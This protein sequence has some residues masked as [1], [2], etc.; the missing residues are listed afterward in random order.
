MRSELDKML[1]G[2]LYDALHPDLQDD[3][4]LRNG[5]KG[6]PRCGDVTGPSRHTLDREA[7]S[8]P[9]D[10]PDLAL[11]CP[12]MCRRASGDLETL[13]RAFVAQHGPILANS[14]TKHSVHRMFYQQ[15][16]LHTKSR[17]WLVPGRRERRC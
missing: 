4:R 2:E 5:R 12:W 9:T 8:L 1:A 11:A 17:P 15:F 6:N 3:T 14:G 7:E 10:I 16:G 13:L